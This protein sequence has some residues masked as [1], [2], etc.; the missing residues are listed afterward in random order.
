MSLQKLP[1]SQRK[2]SLEVYAQIIFQ[3]PIEIAL[4]ESIFSFM[5]Y[6]K[7]KSAQG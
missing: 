6:N 1:E 4:I 3:L 2:L 5:N 7:E